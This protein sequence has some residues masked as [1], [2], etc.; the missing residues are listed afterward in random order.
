MIPA[1]GEYI[2]ADYA[3]RI[4]HWY[5][6]SVNKINQLSRIVYKKKDIEIHY[7]RD[8][9]GGPKYKTIER[10]TYIGFKSKFPVGC[11]KA[12]SHG[13]G[14]TKGIK[15]FAKFI[16][17]EYALKEV[18]ITKTGKLHLD[19]ENQVLH[20]NEA[21]LTQIQNA[22]SAVFKKNYA[23]VDFV[24]W[25]VLYGLFPKDIAKPEKSYIANTLAVSLSQWS[26]DISEF[27]TQDKRAIQDLFDKLSLTSDF[28]T[29]DSLAKTKEIIDV[30]YIQEALRAYKDLMEL[31]TDSESLESQW[32]AF[33][34]AN[35]WIFSS[36]FAQP[37]ILH[38]DEAYVGGKA[39]DNRGGKFNDFLLKNSLSEN[40]SFLEIKTHKTK[41][42]EN[43]PYRGD[44]VFS[45]SKDLSGC[46]VQVLN[47]RDNFQKEFYAL[48]VKAGDKG[49]FKTFN[50]KCVVL[51]GSTSDL[52]DKQKYSFELFR[53]NSRDVEI[54]TFDELQAKIESLQ[55]LMTTA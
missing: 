39:I 8:F 51:I 3:D 26:D 50:S 7:P 43:S 44:D 21:S 19:L 22:F 27:S 24:L 6:D 2:K 36:I 14:F 10:F 12:I 18:I 52:T 41:L 54:I 34:Q 23:E 11:V 45:S 55:T 20:L 30:K 38:K 47:Q 15:P 13:W 35:S 28:L 25:I 48:K 42:Q 40:V 4:E 32:H 46:I 17:E 31:K 9:N 1:K 5:S 53:S 33:L 29:S 16:N 37:V 49:N